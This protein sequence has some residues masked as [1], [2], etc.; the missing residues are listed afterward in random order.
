MKAGNF[1]SYISRK[2]LRLA[3]VYRRFAG[4]SPHFDFSLESLVECYR[5]ETYGEPSSRKNGYVFGKWAKDISVVTWIE[6]ILKGDACKAEFIFGIDSWWAKPAL[7]NVIVP[8]WFPHE[9]R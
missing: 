3:A 7:E 4:R 2:Y 6:D 1:P 9:G 8:T 5:H